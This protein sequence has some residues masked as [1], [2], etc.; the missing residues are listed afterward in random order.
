MSSKKKWISPK[1]NSLVWLTIC[2]I[3]SKL[4]IKLA[5]AYRFP[6]RS[7]K[8]GLDLQ[9]QKTISLLITITIS[10]NF[11]IEKFVYHSDLQTTILAFFLSKS[12]N[13]TVINLFLQKL[14][15]LTIVKFTISTR[16]DITLQTSVKNFRAITM[17]SAFTLDCGY[18][19]STIILLG[20]VHFSITWQKRLSMSA[21]WVC[22]PGAQH[23]FWRSK[24]F[25]FLV[26]CSRGLQFW[27]EPKI[28]S[29]CYWRCLL[30]W[31][32]LFQQREM[33]NSWWLCNNSEILLC[34][35]KV[36]CLVVCSKRSFYITRARK[37]DKNRQNTFFLC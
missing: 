14:S 23:S 17:C 1:E 19:N 3:F 36:W 7:P 16:T 2:A 28:S 9:S 11:Q 15:A 34:L 31:R 21:M 33:R 6:Y 24:K 30:S 18:N 35:W 10:L 12:L 22:V 26:A 20:D 8:L 5:S 13:Y 37:D 29:K 27:R 4:L 32:V 25:L